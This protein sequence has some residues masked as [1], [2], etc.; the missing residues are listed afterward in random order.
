MFNLRIS[1]RLA[2]VCLIALAALTAFA[3]S[4]SAAPAPVISIVAQ[5]FDNEPPVAVA[6]ADQLLLDAGDDLT[7]S[8]TVDG[9]GSSDSDGSIASFAWSEGVTPLAST[10]IATFDLS[11]GTHTLTLTVTDDGGATTTDDV[12][13]TINR[14]PVADAGPDQLVTDIDANG[15]ESVTLDGTA[16]VDH[17]GSLV[18]YSWKEGATEI[19]TGVQP[20]APLSAGVHTITLN[21]TDDLGA[22]ATDTVVITVNQ[23]PVADAGDDQVVTDQDLNSLESVTLDGSGSADPDGSIATYQWKNG[24]TVIATG[25]SPTVDLAP[26]DYSL[27]LVVTDDSGATA[28]DTVAV[29]VNVLPVANAGPDQTVADSDGNGAQD[30]TLDGTDSTDSDGTIATYRWREGSIN[31]ASGSSPTVSLPL[32]SH[33]LTLTV[34]DN[35]GG[36]ATDTVVIVIEEQAPQPCTE[37]PVGSYCVE[38]F[39]G[40]ELSGPILESGPDPAPLN[41]DWASGGPVEGGPVN[42]FSARWQG[43]FDFEFAGT[44]RFTGLMDDGLRIKIDGE[45]IFEDWDNHRLPVSFD[46]F[47]SAGRHTVV[48]EYFEN[49]GFATVQLDWDILN[50][51]PIANAGP[52]QRWADFDGNGSQPITLDGSASTDPGGAIDTYVW[53]RGVTVIATTQTANVVLPNGTHTLELRVSDSLGLKSVDTVTIIIK[54][55]QPVAMSLNKTADIVNANYRVSLSGYPLNSVATVRFNN[56]IAGTIALDS[57]GKG[58]AT[59]KV[60]KLPGSVYNIN[61]R[62]G[63]TTAGNV[64]FTIKPRMKLIPVTGERGD[65][66][67]ISLTGMTPNE[68]VRIRWERP[69]GSFS[70]LRARLPNG[71]VTTS[72]AVGADGALTVTVNVP[73]FSDG[74]VDKVRAEGTINRMQTGFTVIEP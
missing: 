20:S 63:A 9:S 56:V 41:H 24:S 65:R 53:I 37:L 19:G 64:Q 27:D 58:S 40:K 29:V 28:S 43:Q 49:V 33:T 67:Q 62:S 4:V 26:G 48:I 61:A 30:V 44:Y 1:A 70:T 74:G 34:T 25:V 7:E 71:T 31:V 15:T 42:A 18:T 3:T 14:I 23:P 11:A 60:P 68:V 5:S 6:G 2:V 51:A 12:V 69:T 46:E 57:E 21:V 39:G 55:K 54:S 50:A 35:D 17:D 10:A 59:F 66:I 32:G 16:S 22:T 38:Y 13:V 45:T 52:D 72:F 73:A 36:T 47:I 8:V